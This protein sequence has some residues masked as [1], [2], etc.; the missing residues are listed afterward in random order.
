[1]VFFCKACAVPMLCTGILP[2]YEPDDYITVFDPG[3]TRV[4]VFSSRLLCMILRL[5]MILRSVVVYQ[6]TCIISTYYITFASTSQHVSQ[7]CFFIHYYYFFF[8]LVQFSSFPVFHHF[9]HCSF[10]RPTTTKQQQQ[11]TVGF[12]GGL[13]VVCSLCIIVHR[14]NILS[15][16]IFQEQR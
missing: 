4:H 11:P 10:I 13:F 3:R 1:M 12:C 2:K 8:S 5:S 14:L 15:S 6:Y 16:T 7:S 9:H